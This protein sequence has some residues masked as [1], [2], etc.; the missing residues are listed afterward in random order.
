MRLRRLHDSRHAEF[1]ARP[2]GFLAWPE[3]FCSGRIVYPI[4]RISG[5]TEGSFFGLVHGIYDSP[6]IYDWPIFCPFANF[7]LLWQSLGWFLDSGFYQNELLATMAFS[8]N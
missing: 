6:R 2:P 1:P 7:A 4:H 3:P 5:Q 8:E